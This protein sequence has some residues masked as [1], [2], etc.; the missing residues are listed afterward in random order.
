[1]I[2][3]AN[4]YN[5]INDGWIQYFLNLSDEKL[6]AHVQQLFIP[7]YYTDDLLGKKILVEVEK[8]DTYLLVNGIIRFYSERKF[9][10]YKQKLTLAYY[11]RN[12]NLA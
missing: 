6:I 4:D 8:D 3:D 9:L 2:Y 1:M 12:H 7:F 11:A 10:S 5:V